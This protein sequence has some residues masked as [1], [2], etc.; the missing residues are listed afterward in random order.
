MIDLFVANP[1]LLLFTVSALGYAIGRLKF[2]GTSLGVAAVLFVGLAFG[3]LSPELV[4]PEAILDL[5]LVIFVYSIGLSSGPGFLASFQRK[6]L[7]D[8]LFVLGM[9]LLA[10]TLAAVASVLLALEPAVTAGL[11]AGSLTNTPA[12]AALLDNIGRT[13]PADLRQSLQAAPVIG[14]SVA[15]PVGVLGVILAVSVMQH[16]WQIDYQAEA[17]QLRRFH[18]VE[19][20]LY[21]QTVRVTRPGVTGIALREL[22]RRYQWKALFSR[23]KR[24]E[25]MTLARA[26]TR[27]QIDDLVNVI[28]IPEDVAAVAEKLGEPASEHLEL[29]RTDYDFR[30]IFVSNPEVV[31]RRLAELH[32]PEQYGAIITRVRRGDIDLLAD[33]DTILELGDRVRVVGRRSDMP[34]FGAL[35][36]D[37]YRAL[38]EIDLLSFGLGISLGLL[39]GAIP[40]PLPGGL[41]LR[42]GLAGGPLIVGLILGALRR[43]GPILWTMPYSAGLTLR[44]LGLAMLL[45]AIGVRSGYTFVTTLAQSGGL[46]IFLAGALITAA[47]A[48][49]TLWIGYR[50]LKIPFGMLS[51]MLAGLQTQPAVLGYSLEQADNELPNIG[52]SLVYPVATIA[53]IV[54]AQVLLVAL[55]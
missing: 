5:G 32:L 14:Y 11:Y 26:Q 10:G 53:K 21:L 18:L 43:S 4:L 45:A 29:D 9:V 34:A 33:A 42:L 50:R 24:G 39:V 12:L 47:T 15:Y 7:R 30:R 1:L 6:G 38:S 55:K 44:Q 3:A 16:R 37:S 22:R 27:L 13:A 40:I 49:L 41:T 52:Y 2:R 35:F 20:Q 31:G 17:R 36:G 46:A 25:N 28:G 54:I 19:Q 23:L 8:N 48:F 51:G